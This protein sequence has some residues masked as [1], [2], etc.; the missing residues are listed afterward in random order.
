MTISDIKLFR[1]DLDLVTPF[2]VKGRP[3][4]QRSGFILQLSAQGCEGYGE[5]A[6]LPGFSPDT[7][8]EALIQVRLLASFLKSDPV[9]DGL[10]K[11]ENGFDNW[12]GNL[13]LNP[14]V[15]FG[16]EMAILNLWANTQSVTL[17]ELVSETSHTQIPISGLL[18]GQRDQVVEQ[19]RF[20]IEE[21]FTAFKLKV[22]DQ[23]DA[24]IET[25]KQ[26]S[27]VTSGK[28][29]LHLDANKAWTLEQAIEFGEAVGPAAIDYIEEPLQDVTAIPEFFHRTL[30]PSA[31]D[32]SLQTETFDTLKTLEGVDI[33]VLKPSILGS[34]EL[35]WKMMQECKRLGFESL[36][37]SIFE[38][39]IG[40]I[41]LANLAGC[42]FRNTPAGLDTDK[43]MSQCVLNEP[44]AIERGRMDI[45]NRRVSHADI[46][47]DLLTP[48]DLS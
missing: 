3:L 17:K 22:T 44:L 25:V 38:S 40:L 14:S 27:A 43:W 33:F 28:A 6:P 10:V 45:T 11:L 32:E 48:I 12:L 39:S 2:M 5:I 26:V 20:M 37:S 8:D 4:P 35:T 29:L 16:I 7:L 34:I 13:N 36:I 15:Q 23:I 21:G 41:T 9:P 47:W 30:I 19:A 42:S 18:Q 31:I 24:E 1:Y 46:N